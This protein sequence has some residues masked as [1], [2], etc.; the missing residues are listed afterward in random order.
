[1]DEKKNGAWPIS[2]SIFKNVNINSVNHD[3]YSIFGR[4]NIGSLSLGLTN[5]KTVKEFTGSYS[6]SNIVLKNSRGNPLFVGF[7][8]VNT[9]DAL[10]K[11]NILATTC[12]FLKYCSDIYQPSAVFDIAMANSNNVSINQ[13]PFVATS[14][15]ERTV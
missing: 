13:D 14:A 12:S 1:L 3:I 5:Y 10:V 8:Y 2:A 15:V 6:Q 9:T 11:G 7:S 4:N